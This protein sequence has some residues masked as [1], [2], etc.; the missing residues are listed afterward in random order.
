MRIFSSNVP[1]IFDPVMLPVVRMDGNCI[2]NA[3]YEH[4]SCHFYNPD[5]MYLSHSR[6]SSQLEVI[7]LLIASFLD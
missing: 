5:C 6:Y 4:C 1:L 3:G 7:E 2:Y